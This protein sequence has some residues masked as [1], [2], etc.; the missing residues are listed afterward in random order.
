MSEKRGAHAKGVLKGHHYHQY[1][2][3]E[4]EN[5]LHAFDTDY[6]GDNI[7][8]FCAD[9]GI[10]RLTFRNWLKKRQNNETTK[11]PLFRS[12]K[13]RNR[14]SAH[15][16]LDTLLFEW[17][18][19]HRKRYGTIPISRQ[20][21]LHQAV[22][23]Q[24]LLELPL[25]AFRQQTSSATNVPTEVSADTPDASDFTFTPDMF[26]EQFDNIAHTKQSPKEGRESS[27]SAVRVKPY[28]GLTNPN[29]CCFLNATL[30]QLFAFLPFRVAVTN[31][32]IE[33]TGQESTLLTHDLQLLF[34][35]MA[36]PVITEAQSSQPIYKKIQQIEGSALVSDHQYDAGECLEALIS[37][38][39][40]ETKQTKAGSISFMDLLATDLVIERICPMGHINE[41]TLHT[42]LWP[43]PLKNNNSLTN[44][45]DSLRYGEYIGSYRCPICD[46]ARTYHGQAIQRISLDHLPKVLIIQ[47]SRFVFISPKHSRKNNSYF[48]FPD[49]AL[50]D[51]NPYLHETII[52]SES[53]YTG[54]QLYL[55]IKT[56]LSE[57]EMKG[58]QQPR[59]AEQAEAILIDDDY[60]EPET[61][62]TLRSSAR[63]VPSDYK[64]ISNG[65]EAMRA[66]TTVISTDLTDERSITD[67]SPPEESTT[68]TLQTVETAVSLSTLYH[69]QGVVTHRGVIHSGH[70][71]SFIRAP[72]KPEVWYK[73]DDIDVECTDSL[74]LPPD[75]FGPT[76]HVRTA[77]AHTS[78]G[79]A[80]LL[81]YVPGDVSQQEETQQQ[82]PTQQ[83]G[84]S[85]E[86]MPVRISSSYE[87]RSSTQTVLP[88]DSSDSESNKTQT[89]EE[90]TSDDT[91]DDTVN[92]S[93]DNWL[94][95]WLKRRNIKLKTYSGEA[96]SADISLKQKWLST[97]YTDL[98]KKFNPDDIWNADE[99]GLFYTQISRRT[100]CQGSEKPR[101]GKILK[102]RISIMFAASLTGAKKRPLL[103]H[104]TPSL[105]KIAQLSKRPF[106]YAQQQN[107]WMTLEL[108]ES[109]LNDW[110]SELTKCNRFIALIVD[111]CRIHQTQR[112]YSNITLIFLPACQTSIL[113]PMDQGII[114]SFKAIYRSLLLQLKIKAEQGAKEPVYRLPTYIQLICR[115]WCRVTSKTIINCFNAAGWQPT[116]SAEK[117]VISVSKDQSKSPNKSCNQTQIQHESPEETDAIAALREGL[118]TAT[119]VEDNTTQPT[120]TTQGTTEEQEDEVIID[121][122]AENAESFEAFA[123]SEKER[124]LQVLGFRVPDMHKY[125]QSAIYT[126]ETSESE[127][128][129]SDRYSDSKVTSSLKYVEQY[130]GRIPPS[131][132]RNMLSAMVESIREDLEK[133]T[134]ETP[135]V[136]PKEQS[137]L[138]QTTLVLSPMNKQ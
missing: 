1:T 64:R 24:K 101:G 58:L 59:Q 4:R 108:F 66:S 91:T 132:R 107:C 27:S 28:L 32:D 116:P 34:L 69:L 130:I 115:A 13:Y 51:L 86:E 135:P 125:D 70:Y 126:T 14:L 76:H 49:D 114:R 129:D 134:L 15:P 83:I 20:V 21:L 26:V 105:L 46:P 50:L 96:G 25:T 120:E 98:L 89:V 10:S 61:G 62:P 7:T 80:Y 119:M 56:L 54:K 35:Q 95:G 40:S 131:A 8:Q 33:R 9:K 104:R 74:T 123:V 47:L 122:P 65:L 121:L 106:D 97:I 100:Y 42:L 2:A 109:W 29:R 128:T 3:Q 22:Y 138:I 38:L 79:S 133:K 82:T 111:G 11:L 48:T 112:S 117:K 99:A 137:K 6:H 55:Y 87:S 41:T 43:I 44:A 16:E 77:A 88:P 45:L 39:D 94:S 52:R 103:I 81:F 72:E 102:H 93:L 12:D 57:Y 124:V 23:F 53:S 31:S 37:T 60:D 30:Q 90:S 118:S 75:V 5:L 68:V 84:S 110:N 73:V 113:Q 136:S 78:T 92:R 127:T 67:E 17:F 85:P 63:K 36:N 18:L 19:D 71:I